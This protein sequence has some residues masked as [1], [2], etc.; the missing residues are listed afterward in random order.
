MLRLVNNKTKV[1]FIANPN[2]PTGTFLTT[3]QL[4]SFLTELPADIICVLDEAYFEY[5]SPDERSDS[6]AWLGFFPNLIITRTFSKAYGL[7]GM[8][9]G[10]SVSSAEIADLLNRVRQPFNTNF[11]ALS[12]AE[13]SLADSEYLNETIALNQQG[14]VQLTGAF[15]ALGLSWIPSKGNFITVN[16]G[17]PAMTI[18]EDLLKAGVIVRPIANYGLPNFLRISIGT[19]SENRFFIDALINVLD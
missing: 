1:V 7:A 14:M 2:N 11:M 4:Y 3:S 16:L 8:R 10:Y 19:E 18:Y 13:A 9:I 5:V 17:R 12:A 6:I 15:T